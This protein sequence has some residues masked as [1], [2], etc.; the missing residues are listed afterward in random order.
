MQQQILDIIKDI[1]KVPVYVI[2]FVAAMCIC[3]TQISSCAIEMDK[4]YYE[5]RI[6]RDKNS[7]EQSKAFW[8]RSKPSNVGPEVEN[9]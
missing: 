2:M 4:H 8:N 9:Q 6:Q 3:V 1:V 5:W 7:A